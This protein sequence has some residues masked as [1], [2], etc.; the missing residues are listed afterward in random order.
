MI[1]TSSDSGIDFLKSTVWP[2]SLKMLMQHY[3]PQTRMSMIEIEAAGHRCVMHKEVILCGTSSTPS[4]A[5]TRTQFAELFWNSRC[6]MGK[7]RRCT[8]LVTY[9]TPF[10]LSQ[11]QQQILLFARVVRVLNVGASIRESHRVLGRCAY[12]YYILAYKCIFMIRNC[13][14]TGLPGLR[15]PFNKRG[16]WR[17]QRKT[18]Q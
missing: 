18:L 6:C 15:E 11:F 14:C 2:L 3:V 13:I 8:L 17:E 9:L 10:I 1:L 7:G 5:S 12:R 4:V 16:C